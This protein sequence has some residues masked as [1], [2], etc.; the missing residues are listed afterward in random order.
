MSFQSTHPCGV[1]Q[2]SRGCSSLRGTV[3]IHA[4]LRGATW[5]PSSSA[6]SSRF[7]PRTPAGCDQYHAYQEALAR[8]VSIHAP[9]RGATGLASGQLATY[10]KF[11]S[12][13]PCG[14]R[15]PI[16]FIIIEEV[17]V[18][19]H[20]PLRGATPGP[21]PAVYH[22]SWF[23]STHPCGVR[24]Y[25]I[26]K[27]YG[28]RIVSIHA[29]LRGATKRPSYEPNRPRGFNPRTPAGC[30]VTPEQTAWLEHLFQS[31]HPC[32][33]RLTDRATRRLRK[34]MFQSTHPC[35]VRL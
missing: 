3:S 30:D 34:Q 29:P 1:R 26:A 33:V 22:G 6:F 32:G 25:Y 20:A 21:G 11:Q 13:H 14:V 2:G 19:I 17:G 16:I 12:T 24:R 27:G 8:S 7:N 35:G 18:S 23:Q 5:S 4:P 10:D 9:L 28:N 15:Q 31:T